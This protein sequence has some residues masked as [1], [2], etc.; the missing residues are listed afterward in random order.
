MIDTMLNPRVRIELSKRADEFLGGL[1]IKVDRKIVFNI[2]LGSGKNHPRLFKK[3][4]KNIWE[5]RT[6][7][8]RMHYRLFAFWDKTEKE[9]ILVIG[10]HGVVKK[11]QKIDRKE[12]DKAEKIRLEYFK[13]KSGL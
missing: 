13:A 7:S 5:F 2:D 4:N 9:D 6:H 3:L 10:T 1:P 12:I 11:S 8:G